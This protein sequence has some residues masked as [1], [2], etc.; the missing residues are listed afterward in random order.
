MI[1]AAMLTVV[2]IRDRLSGIRSRSVYPGYP[3]CFDP[4]PDPASRILDR[5]ATPYTAT[6]EIA[7]ALPGARI[8]RTAARNPR[9]RQAPGEVQ[10]PV[11]P[12][13][14]PPRVPPK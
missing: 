1:I 10:S 11:S 4:T 14:Q 3:H 5:S 7:V 6:A 2:G 9:R 13:P 8:D 12:P